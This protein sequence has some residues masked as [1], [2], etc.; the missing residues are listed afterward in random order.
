MVQGD[1]GQVCTPAA[2]EAIQ[3]CDG[4]SPGN[5]RYVEAKK[6]INVTPVD[7]YHDVVQQ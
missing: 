1:G 3:S 4:D 7:R 5:G 2:R 6:A